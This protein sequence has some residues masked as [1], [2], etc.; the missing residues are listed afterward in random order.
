[1]Q[2]L[3]EFKGT[4]NGKS[5]TYKVMRVDNEL[6]LESYNH[7]GEMVDRLTWHDSPINEVLINKAC[8]DIEQRG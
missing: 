6:M 3:K 5:Y 7:D 8:L 4:C 2:V 1:M